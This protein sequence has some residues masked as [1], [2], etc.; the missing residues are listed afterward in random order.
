MEIDALLELT[1]AI[2]N[3]AS[4]K[5]LFRIYQFT[6]LALYQVNSMVVL[7]K[8][9]EW[10][11]LFRL[12]VTEAEAENLKVNQSWA[13]FRKI[14]KIDAATFEAPENLKWIIPVRHK[15]Q[16]LAFVLIDDFKEGYSTDKP[17]DNFVITITNIIISAVENKRLFKQQLE[18]ARF[19]KELELAEQVQSM[20]V[21]ST[22]PDSKALDIAAYYKPYAQIGGDYY[23]VFP[24][25]DD[26]FLICIADVAGK[27]I[28]A[29]LLMANFQAMLRA[30]SEMRFD[31]KRL[32]EYL[33][34]RICSITK[35]ERF[36]TALLAVYKKSDRS[37]QFINAGHLP[38]F[39]IAN[40]HLSELFEGCTVLGIREEL[41][42]L[43]QG[44]IKLG[45]NNYLVLYTDGLTD[46]ENADGTPFD[47]I[48]CL[49]EFSENGYSAQ[50][51]LD[52]LMEEIEIFS[53]VNH[54]PDDL[55][56]LVVRVP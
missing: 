49:K 13:S 8:N 10:D 26:E 19:N 40:G 45:H 14:T 27:N 18:Q 20:L 9:K 30:S 16:F 41:P 52:S 15:N 44:E 1:E 47:P 12:G 39:H 37:L 17:S 25:S 11:I 3:N 33:N 6:L 31:L 43:E 56:I 28:S 53:P 36:I 48:S 23:D 42:F 2:N 7:Y 50:E 21:P 51:M 38:M 55:T 35:G 32:T 24:I 22:F 46:I 4:T 29:A 5:N 34:K 54:R